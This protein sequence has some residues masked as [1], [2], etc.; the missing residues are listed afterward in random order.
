MANPVVPATMP[1]SIAGSETQP[2]AIRRF[3]GG[4][5]L[6]EL[7]VVL[8][9]MAFA[10]M[11]VTPSL[12]RLTTPRPQLSMVDGLVSALAWARDRAIQERSTFRGFLFPGAQ[13]W[14]QDAEG[15]VLYQLP[16]GSMI[17]PEDS[18]SAEPLPCAFLPDGSGCGLSIRVAQGNQEW[19]LNVD[20]VTGRI[21]LLRY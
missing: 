14:W 10:T 17:G 21:R 20:P 4:F 7:L 19:E 12:Q 1:T 6:V 11:A 8:A 9:I 2:A 16:V 5:T 15:N 3:I 13:G 18:N